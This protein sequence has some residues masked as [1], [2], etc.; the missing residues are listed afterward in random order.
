M[1]CLL[2]PSTQRYCSS[3]YSVQVIILQMLDNCAIL[4]HWTPQ[5]FQGTFCKTLWCSTHTREVFRV[6]I[7]RQPWFS[8]CFWEFRMPYHTKASF[9]FFFLL[10]HHYQL[11]REGLSCKLYMH[12]HLQIPNWLSFYIQINFSYNNSWRS[13]LGCGM[14]SS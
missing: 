14:S 4:R 5:P 2:Q 13:Y 9:A 8:L 1:V 10:L 6:V 12:L 3:L 7:D 11:V